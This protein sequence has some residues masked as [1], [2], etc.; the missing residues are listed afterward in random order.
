MRF[1]RS[2]FPFLTDAARQA[3]IPLL[4]A[5]LVDASGKPLFTGHLV[6]QDGSMK[7][8][9]VAL[10]PSGNYGTALVHQDPAPAAHAS[11]RP[12]RPRA[13]A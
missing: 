11:C 4:S 3:G 10:S 2:E 13:A 7:V 12:W 9:A 8:C 5:N 1:S 6:F